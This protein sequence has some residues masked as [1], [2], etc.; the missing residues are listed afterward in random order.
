MLNSACSTLLTILC[1]LNDL[2]EYKPRAVVRHCTSAD[3]P[4]RKGGGVSDQSIL[5]DD[6]RYA[7]LY[8]DNFYIW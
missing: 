1:Y 7:Y 2:L 8:G 3:V 4:N 6:H 5:P